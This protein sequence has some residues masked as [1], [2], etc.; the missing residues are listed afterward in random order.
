[1]IERIIIQN[2]KSIREADVDLRALNVLIGANGAGKSNFVSFFRLVRAL[3]EQRL[4]S[5]VAQV[6]GAERFLYR[7]R[8]VSPCILAC[9]DFDNTN[10]LAVKLEPTHND[11]FFISEFR[12]YFN[13]KGDKTKSYSEWHKLTLD[14][15]VEESNVKEL[16]SWRAG[17]IKEHLSSFTV[18]QF[19]D[20][21]SNSPMRLPCQLHDNEY[22]RG[23]GSNLAAYLYLL[24]ETEPRA[25][26]WIEATIRLIAPYFKGFR[27]K[28]NPLN[29]DTIR[30]E[31]EEVDT[32]MY[33]DAQSF[34]DGTLRF[35]ALATLL[36]QPNPPQTIIIDEP[37]LGLHPAAIQRLGALVRMASRKSQIIL[38]TQ[39]TNL[40]S[41][42]EPEDLLVV[43]KVDGATQIRRLAEGELEVWLEEYSLGE[44]WEKNIIGAKP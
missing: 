28:P 44:I 22:L 8:K 1:M 4:G 5:Y 16:K 37:E 18:Y 19:H 17:Y 41:C 26:R 25:F 27:L 36:L 21:S 6:G 38:S 32:D 7:G 24:Q 40:I 23:D 9:I 30:L 20:T 39:S 34:S 14:Q 29:P 43:D 15:G 12:D 33:L 3:L 10:T 42:F 13:N 2:F 11:T 31:W 35:I